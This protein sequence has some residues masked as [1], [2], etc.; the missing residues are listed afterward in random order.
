MSSAHPALSRRTLF[1]MVPSVLATVLAVLGVGIGP[2]TAAVVPA[3]STTSV[4][5]TECT[6]R[7][8]VKVS[9]QV[10]VAFVESDV[11]GG[12]PVAVGAPV[13]PRDG[14]ALVRWT[15]SVRGERVIVARQGA[16]YSEPVPVSIRGGS[17]WCAER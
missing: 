6:Y 2:A 13:S 16:S 7:L 11:D 17:Q 5:G 15:P 8:M 14:V 9:Q 12:R 1:A 4:Y 10:D 3:S